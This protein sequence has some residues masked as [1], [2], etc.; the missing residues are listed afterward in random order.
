MKLIFIHENSKHCTKF[1]KIH[2]YFKKKLWNLHKNSKQPTQKSYPNINP[3]LFSTVIN[4]LATPLAKSLVNLIFDSKNSVLA[5]LAGNTLVIGWCF[6]ICQLYDLHA[7]TNLMSSIWVG[8]FMFFFAIYNNCQP[9][10]L[11]RLVKN[12]SRRFQ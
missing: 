4:W 9:F 7:P 1:T 5:E 10:L 8:L 2:T 12:I 11:S 3:S 6:S